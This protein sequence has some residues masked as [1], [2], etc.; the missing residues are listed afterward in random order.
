MNKM[1]KLVGLFA[2]LIIGQITFGQTNKE[3]AL[4]KAKEAVKLE[5]EEGKYDEAI[6]LFDE[7]QKLD[8]ENISYPYEM[9]YAYNG[10]KEYKKASDILE[11]LLNH[12]SVHA[13]VYQSLGNAYDYQ[14]KADKALETYEK[15]AKKFPNS[16][17]LY[18]EMGNM[19][20]GKQEYDKALPFKSDFFYC[21]FIWI[22]GFAYTLCF[23]HDSY[24]S[25]FL[26]QTK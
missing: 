12:K 5:D 22:C 4:Q 10:K 23:P 13:L 3:T 2:L 1:I 18:L 20:L 9:A 6:K 21:F 7:A 17:E 8:P 19:K 24:D 15:G 11:K 25:E 16:G 14:G 26:Y